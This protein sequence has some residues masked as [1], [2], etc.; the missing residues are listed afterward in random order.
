MNK[1]GSGRRILQLNFPLIVH[2][3][4]LTTPPQL[5]H[6][7]VPTHTIHAYRFGVGDEY[8]WRNQGQHGPPGLLE[9]RCQVGDPPMPVFKYLVGS[10]LSS[11][12]ALSVSQAM[13]SSS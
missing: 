5:I 8:S 9:L 4:L 11:A 3:V 1:R 6:T 12:C 13:A 7:Q 10:S 2:A